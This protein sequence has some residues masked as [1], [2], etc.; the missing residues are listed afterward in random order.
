[1]HQLIAEDSWLASIP[2]ARAYFFRDGKPLPVG[3]ILKNPDL[4]ET[5][6]RL[7][8]GGSCG[9]RSG[10]QSGSG[11]YLAAACLI[12]GVLAVSG[13]KRRGPIQVSV[14]WARGK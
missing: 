7:A 9:R 13:V 12:H 14:S 6:R 3:A 8:E 10:A 2:A 1:M 5:L 4:A 11:E